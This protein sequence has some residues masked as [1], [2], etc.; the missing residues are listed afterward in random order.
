MVG[1]VCVQPQ[2]AD[3]M[4][5]C[6]QKGAELCWFCRVRPLVIV[7]LEL[8]VP[9]QGVPMLGLGRACSGGAEVCALK[10]GCP[11]FGASTVAAAC[12]P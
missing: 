2:P 4:M 1:T 12:G 6:G 11:P 8:M 7:G 9:V 3:C 10:L 5:D